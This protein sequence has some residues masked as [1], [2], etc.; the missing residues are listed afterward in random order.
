MPNELFF[1]IVE[2]AYKFGFTV[3]N[4]TPMIGEVLTDPGFLQKLDFLEAHVGVKSFSFC[5]NLSPG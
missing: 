2:K 1:D 3:F 5:T 4:V